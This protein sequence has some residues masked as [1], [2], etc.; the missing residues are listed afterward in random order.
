M[1]VADTNDG[2]MAADLWH[3]RKGDIGMFA[4]AQLGGCNERWL[5]RMRIPRLIFSWY[6]GVMAAVFLGLLTRIVFPPEPQTRPMILRGMALFAL[7]AIFGIAAWVAR[8]GIDSAEVKGRF[9]TTLAG[10]LSLSLSI[11]I[12]LIIRLEAGWGFWYLQIA[13]GLPTVLGL[14]GLMAFL[15]PGGPAAMRIEKMIASLRVKGKANF[16]ESSG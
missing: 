7:T 9:W 3:L 1:A 15:T 6:L 11:G 13:F 8:K 14:V 2:V 16:P 10:L 5:Q 12:P 4:H